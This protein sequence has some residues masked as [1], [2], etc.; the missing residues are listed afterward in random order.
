M[1]SLSNRRIKW[2]WGIKLPLV[3][4]SRIFQTCSH[5]HWITLIL[6][7]IDFK[8]H[9]YFHHKSST[10][11][12]LY[13]IGRELLQA[14]NF[15]NIDCN[16]PSINS[17][18]HSCRHWITLTAIMI[19]S[20]INSLYRRQGITLTFFTEHHPSILKPTNVILSILNNL[21]LLL[22]RVSWINIG[23]SLGKI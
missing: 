4:V 22:S 17:A 20:K 13:L 10:H 6:I 8:L 23:S 12:L 16:W 9:Y 7:V 3:T 18:P 5:R 11:Y 1:Y 14:A 15:F 21:K 19:G 2:T